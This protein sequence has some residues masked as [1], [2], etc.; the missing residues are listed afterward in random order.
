MAARYWVGGAGAVWN[1]TV[2]TK[3]ATTSGGAGGASVPTAADDV[4]FDANSTANATTAGTIACRSLNFTGYAKTFTLVGTATLNIGDATA[5]AGNVALKIVS[6]MTFSANNASA[7]INFASTSATQQTVDTQNS[8]IYVMNFNGVGG[9]WI[10]NSAL[11]STSMGVYAGT[12]NTNNYNVTASGPFT[13]AS[14]FPRTLTLGTTTLS[15]YSADFTM[16]NGGT[17][18][19]SSAT[20]TLNGIVDATHALAGSTWN[21]CNMVSMHFGSTSR[22]QII[23]GANTFGSLYIYPYLTNTNTITWKFPASTTQTVTGTFSVVGASGDLQILA[24]SSAGTT[25]TI[26]CNTPPAFQHDYASVT[27]IAFTGEAKQF[28]TNSTDGGGNRNVWF[29]VIMPARASLLGCGV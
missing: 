12:L 16:T 3:W 23:T 7:T 24:S 21:R 11:S 25:A 29:N 1:A 17:L 9:S 6:G 15:C 20:L 26:K 5:G 13:T 10:L 4:F 2:G 14:A 19:S 22:T 18:N 28:F 8:P 27:D